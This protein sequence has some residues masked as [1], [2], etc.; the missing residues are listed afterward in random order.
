MQSYTSY[1]PNGNRK[2]SDLSESF[3]IVQACAL[4]VIGKNYDGNSY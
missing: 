1:K 4:A 2:L 3:F